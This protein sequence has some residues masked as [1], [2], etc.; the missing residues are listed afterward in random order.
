MGQLNVRELMH[1]GGENTEMRADMKI[2]V[3]GYLIACKTGSA[4]GMVEGQR[5][6]CDRS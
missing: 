3:I 1:V 2:C 6:G 5:G 4:K